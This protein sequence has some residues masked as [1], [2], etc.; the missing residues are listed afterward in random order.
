[1]CLKQ[2]LFRL[3]SVKRLSII[4]DGGNWSLTSASVSGPALRIVIKGRNISLEL[5]LGCKFSIRKGLA[6]IESNS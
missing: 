4:L 3:Q 1:V 5:E 2:L 6:C